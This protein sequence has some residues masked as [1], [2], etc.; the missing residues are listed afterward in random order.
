M[1]KGNPR[2]TIRVPRGQRE[3]LRA[4][5]EARHCTVS[6]LLRA[7]AHQFLTKEAKNT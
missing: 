5:A 6:D 4:E 3:M 1:S 7:L 2:I